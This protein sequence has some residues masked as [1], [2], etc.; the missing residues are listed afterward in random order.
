V[1]RFEAEGRAIDDITVSCD[2]DDAA[3]VLDWLRDYIPEL[4]DLSKPGAIGEIA[5][6]FASSQPTDNANF[7]KPA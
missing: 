1:I 5:I 2:Q 7:A 3:F 6:Q 4:E